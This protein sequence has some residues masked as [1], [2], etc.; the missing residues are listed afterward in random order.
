MYRSN[1]SASSHYEYLCFFFL[2]IRRPPTS[3]RTD[4]LVPYTTLFRSRPPVQRK[5]RFQRSTSALNRRKVEIFE[6]D[7]ALQLPGPVACEEHCGSV[8]IDATKGGS[9]KAFA[10]RQPIEQFSLIKRRERRSG[11]CNHQRSRDRKRT[12]LNSSH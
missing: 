11:P 1:M 7:L 5:L 8:G 6:F 12:R 4:T 9:A 3:T 10:R 2:M